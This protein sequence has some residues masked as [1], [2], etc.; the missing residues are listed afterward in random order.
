MEVIPLK[1]DGALRLESPVHA[2]DRGLFREWF[3]YPDLDRAG[4]AWV[5]QQANLSRSPRNAVRGLHYS[6]APDGQAKI[7]TC[8]HGDLVDVLVDVRVASPTYGVAETVSMNAGDGTSVYVP[9]GIAH[10]WC[11]TSEWGVLVYLL[12][13][14]YAPELERGIHPLDPDLAIDWHLT[15][16]AVLSPKDAGAPTWQTR[17]SR[18]ELPAF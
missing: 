4:V 11:A 2:D 12:S 9:S 3:K 15:D 14:P 7:V 1:I 16:S 18:H 5:V 13:S 10:G 17:A 6:L 8:A